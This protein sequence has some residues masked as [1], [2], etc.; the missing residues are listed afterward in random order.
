VL[1]TFIPIAFIDRLG[2]RPLLIAVLI[3]MGLG[4]T[5]VGF[6]VRKLGGAQGGDSAGCV[7]TL[8]ALIVFIISFAILAWPGDVGRHQRDLSRR[9]ARA[10]GRGSDG[11]QLG[12]GV[13][14]Q[15]ILPTA[16]NAIGRANTFWLFAA[17]CAL[18][19]IRVYARVPETR[20]RALEEIEA[21]WRASTLR[22]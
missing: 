16:V 18:G 19:L 10:G 22:R 3:G 13:R 1:S 21:S 15:R 12:L 9:R 11:G 17:Y 7:V 4:L 6:A 5:A 2:R 20:C 14:G 8:I